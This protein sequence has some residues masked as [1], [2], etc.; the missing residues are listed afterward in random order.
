LRAENAELKNIVQEYKETGSSVPGASDT[1]V[2][3]PPPIMLVNEEI[4]AFTWFFA[5]G[6]S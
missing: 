4:H 6:K 5:W 3:S 2:S 1:Q